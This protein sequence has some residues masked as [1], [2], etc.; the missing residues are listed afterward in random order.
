MSYSTD[1]VCLYDYKSNEVIWAVNTIHSVQNLIWRPKILTW[2][3]TVL[4]AQ[5]IISDP[6]MLTDCELLV[7][8]YYY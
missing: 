1:V 7:H 2:S 5:K 3:Q 8:N 4:G 6:D